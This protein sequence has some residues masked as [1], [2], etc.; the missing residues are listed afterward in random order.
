MEVRFIKELP[1]EEMLRET[2]AR[3]PETNIPAIMA[4]TRLL[5]TAAELE[6]ALEVYLSEH[7]VSLSRF[8]VLTMLRRYMPDG[9]KPTDL[10]DKIG[11]TRGNMTGLVDGLEKAG[12]ITRRDCKTDRRIV[13]VQLSVE[14][15]KLLDRILPEHL[16]RIESVM[17]QLNESEL[18]KLTSNLEKIRS[19]LLSMNEK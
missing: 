1:T 18:K 6:K 12:L 9:L 3:Y 2:A 15:Q 17:T 8:Y 10:A 11:V 5:G 4:V 7:G 13:Y 19:A 14:G 16:R